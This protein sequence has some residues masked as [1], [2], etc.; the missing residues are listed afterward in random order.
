MSLK[1]LKTIGIAAALTSLIGCVSQN[2]TDTKNEADSVHERISTLSQVKHSSQ[3]RS[4]SRPPIST[5]PLVIKKDIPWLSE[6]VSISANDVPL[7]LVM[8]QVMNGAEHYNKPVRIWFDGDVDP[9]KRVTLSFKASREDV[10]NLIARQTEYGI[11]TTDDKVSISRFESE[12][13]VITIPPGV[14]S[15]Q[16]GSQGTAKS[17]GGGADTLNTRVEGQYL[18]TA[19]KDVDPVTQIKDSIVTLL[20]DNDSDDD[21]LVGSVEVVPAL[22]AIA[23]RTTPSR[24]AQVRSLVNSFQSQFGEQVMLDIRILEFRSNR[25]KERG[26]DWNL[27]KD[28]GSGSL[29]F[30]VPGTNTVS[31]GSAY[32]MAF[33]GTGKWDG[34]TAFI[35]AL[36]KQGT[37]STETPITA[38]ALSNQPSRIAQTL[39]KPYLYEVKSEAN[40]K[41]VS[42]SVTR[43]TQSEGVDM[44][45]TPKVQTDAVWLRIAGKLSKIVGERSETV[46]DVQLQF[47]DTRESEINF[48]NK[49]L[50]GQ[51]VVIGSIKQVSKTAEASKNFG[52]DAL[53]GEGTVSET[54]E[55]LVLLTPRRVQ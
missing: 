47:L 27:V 48:T 23:V 25:G 2:Y 9:N 17:S 29:E 33:K 36:E 5:T 55:T 4:I 31:Q 50:Y 19:Y 18:N 20:K 45:I 21:K 14:Y 24:M 28:I 32:G 51:T 3:V 30:I 37:V 10:L 49:L 43:A 39:T 46:H 11:N 16:L 42:A 1:L 35:K 13:F 7:S 41:V 52:V 8:S 40:D 38:L 6:A 12:T 34:T 15:G 53:G 54:V 44:M 26:V 22:T